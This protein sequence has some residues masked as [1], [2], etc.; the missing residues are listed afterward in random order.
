MG[1]EISA[2]ALDNEIVISDFSFPFTVFHQVINFLSILTLVT[3][4]VFVICFLV[5]RIKNKN[6]DK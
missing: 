6:S 1:A 3:L 5:K 2:V 4:L